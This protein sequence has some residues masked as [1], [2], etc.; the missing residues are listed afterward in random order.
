MICR[1]SG[2]SPTFSYISVGDE[3][4]LLTENESV[5]IPLGVTHRME[6][7]GKGTMVLME[8]QTGSC[9]GE[10]DIVRYE[11]GYARA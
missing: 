8:V 6:T 2:P 3:V 1:P 11:D 9:L 7:P 10:D 5:Y 4:T